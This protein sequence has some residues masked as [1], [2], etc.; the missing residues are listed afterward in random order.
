MYVNQSNVPA[1]RRLL[2]VG[3]TV[4]LAACGGSGSKFADIPEKDPARARSGDLRGIK[5]DPDVMVSADGA[6][7]WV[8]TAVSNYDRAVNDAGKLQAVMAP[9]SNCRFPRPAEDDLVR[10]VIVERGAQEAPIHQ[11]SREDVGERAAKYVE[12]YAASKGRNKKVWDY[13]AADV[14]RVTNV[15]V[16]ETAGPVYLVLSSETN[17]LWNI[18]PASGAHIS[19]IALVSSGGAGVANAPKDAVVNIL[20]GDSLRPCKMPQPMRKPQ[21][22][23]GFVKNAKK[24][25]GAYLKEALANN[26]K[27]AADY[28]RWF[29]DSFGVASETDAVAQLALSNALIG[30]APR[31][32][33][34]PFRAI[35]EGE[36][37]VSRSDYL[38]V[39]PADGYRQ[40]HDE[41]VK[42]AAR[43]A[44][45]GDLDRL[46]A[47]PQ[48]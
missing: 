5:F 3:A 2:L 42:E 24:R 29:T 36:V 16:T 9:P 44:A 37:L 6:V 45:G 18:L 12:Y 40:S 10:H 27:Y 31:G 8:Q 38:I 43:E 11:F 47:G 20:A 19:N 46:I 7:Q 35:D 25:N 30:P 17:V 26:R 48:S 21:D 1:L 15:I 41:L 22:D 32:E 28:S 39:S 14:M 13:D 4:L 23:W 33:K 34:V